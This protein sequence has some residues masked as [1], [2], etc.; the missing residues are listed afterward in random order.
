MKKVMFCF[1]LC[2]AMA[3]TVTVSNV[4]AQLFD[5]GDIVVSAGFGLGST[6]V[7]GWNNY[8]KISVPP[9][10]IAGDYCLRED[11]GPGNLGVGG[12]LAYSAYKYHYT[13]Y[14]YDYGWKYS[15]IMIGARG[16]YHFTDLVD[17]LDLYGGVVIGAKIVTD[18]AFGDNTGADYTVNNS[19][20]LYDLFAGARYYLTDNFA[21]MG[22]LGYGIAWLKAGVSLKL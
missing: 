9:V 21:V 11:L 5:E 14:T 19:G 18:K 1:M 16:S 7:G 17:K 15:T 4:N 13:Y 22:E 2:V 3:L 6:Y 12:I 8:Y 10:F 20:A